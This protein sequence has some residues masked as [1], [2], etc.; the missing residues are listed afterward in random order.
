M[1]SPRGHQLTLRWREKASEDFHCIALCA[2]SKGDTQRHK[3]GSGG[4]DGERAIKIDPSGSCQVLDLTSFQLEW[5]EQHWVV[6]MVSLKDI[7]PESGA[8]RKISFFL[9]I[10]T[11]LARSLSKKHNQKQEEVPT[12]TEWL[13]NPRWDCAPKWANA[14]CCSLCGTRYSQESARNRLTPEYMKG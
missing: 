13:E 3:A 7:C 10:V 2:L 14:V 12:Q 5:V 9:P 8:M 1:T 11:Y 6:G 4:G